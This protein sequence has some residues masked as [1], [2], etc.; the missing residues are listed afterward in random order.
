MKK[1]IFVGI[2]N[3][4]MISCEK[5]ESVN[6]EPNISDSIK[7]E[8]AQQPIDTLGAKS[9]CF[10]KVIGKDTVAASFDDNLGTITGKLA[11]KNN[12]KDSS[13]GDISGFKSGDTLK[14]TYEFVSEGTASKRDIFFLQ[15]NNLLYEG[16]GEL[17]DNGVQMVYTDEKKISYPENQK[18]E[19][20]DCN[21]V[22][23]ILK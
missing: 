4:L 10:M 9:F 23:K 18:F 13:K 7:I 3:L 17:K 22:N 1:L 11:Y 15:K 6:K 14:L 21:T 16:I 12:E 2:V 20:A 19:Q 8:T 5:K